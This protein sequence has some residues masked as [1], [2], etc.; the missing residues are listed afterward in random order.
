MKKYQIILLICL[1]IVTVFTFYPV[2]KADF[3][4]FDDMVMVEGNWKINSFTLSNLKSLLFESHFR[5]YHPVVTLSFAVERALFGKAAYFYHADN[6]ILH[7]FNVLFV[8]FIFFSLTKRNF[9]VSFI[10]AFIFACHPM[11]VEPVAWVTGRKD[12]L[13]AFFFLS[14]F[15]VYL[16]A[17]EDKNRA[18]VYYICSLALFI[19]AC[20][21][22]FPAAL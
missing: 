13:Y 12:V 2:L 16:K 7:L 20:L 21:S 8:F 10:S 5:L 22:K 6:L 18:K 17:A 19:L 14:S 9:F 4:N 15:A 1:M 11:H 3:V